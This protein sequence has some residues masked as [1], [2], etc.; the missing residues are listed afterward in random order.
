MST[1]LVGRREERRRAES[2]LDCAPP[3]P[4]VVALIGEAGIGK[5]RLAKWLAAS[6][7]RSGHGVVWGQAAPSDIGLPLGVFQDLLRAEARREGVAPPADPLAA[8]FPQRVLPEL[9]GAPPGQAVGRD[10]V[11]EAAARWFDGRA[12]GGL[13]VVLDDLHWA[14][15][16]SLALAAHLIRVG[17]PARLRFI[18]AFRDERSTALDEFRRT[19][20]RLAPG[21]E[22]VLGPVSSDEI[23]ELVAG[24]TNERLDAQQL[25]QVA[26]LSG[27]NPFVVEELVLSGIATAADAAS[28]RLTW[29]LHDIVDARLARLSATASETVRWAAV[30]GERFDVTLLGHLARIDGS[31]FHAT[32]AELR[33]A[34]VL[35]DHNDLTDRAERM[36]FRHALTQVAI[37]ERMPA[38][39]RHARHRQILAAFDDGVCVP[40]LEEHLAHAQAAADRGRVVRLSVEAAGRA[41]GQGALSDADAHYRTA[42]ELWQTEDGERLR[43]DLAAEW[44]AL[45]GLLQP[46]PE[47]VERLRDAERRYRAL[48]DEIAAINARVQG[49]HVRWKAGDPS[50][51]S[52][53][54]ALGDELRDAPV[55]ARVRALSGAANTMLLIGGD[56]CEAVRLADQ[57]LALVDQMEGTTATLE[58]LRC[59]NAVGMGVL[60]LG[61]WARARDTLHE[62]GRLAVEIGHPAGPVIALGN[63]VVIGQWD[64]A[65]TLDD[66][67]VVAE[68]ALAEA[69]VR[70]M[71]GYQAWMALSAASLSLRMGRVADTR[72]FREQGAAALADAPDPAYE[73]QLVVVD[74]QM[75]LVAGKLESARRRFAEVLPQMQAAL[76]EAER[77]ARLGLAQ[78]H[79]ALDAPGEALATIA[80]WA[81]LLT[82]RP[83]QLNAYG[84]LLVAGVEAATRDGD[85]RGQRWARLIA[86]IAP[87]PRAEL[88]GALVAIASGDAPPGR[89]LTAALDDLAVSGRVW[90]AARMALVLAGRLPVGSP[91][92]GELAARARTAFLDIHVDGWARRAERLLRTAGSRVASRKTSGG[93]GGLTSREV[94]VLQLVADG[95]SNTD[96]A[97][98]LHLSVA[99]VETHLRNVFR[100]LGVRRRTQAVRVAG[101]Q[102]LLDPV[103][104]DTRRA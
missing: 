63:L 12:R 73:R 94:E 84:S 102:G 93:A 21:S 77:D 25:A 8:G 13:T 90:E 69:T 53:L 51:A 88:A 97:A 9:G 23:A 35:A 48:G 47:A 32:L 76:D 66:V 62:C 34:G 82:D 2:L 43:A 19:L 80:Q 72:R 54:V 55:P 41:A 30:L 71:R 56:P 61:D 15:S 6:V 89:R 101:E 20:A 14:D 74:A 83:E 29:P 39:E 24:L 96:L 98:R 78:A 46:G 52:D 10:V 17:D 1:D 86:Q 42:W 31:D 100:K 26:R 59:L 3:R 11:F 36:A 104:G 103:S 85:E 58:R 28:E 67:A 87:G 37:A 60:Q 79:L 45:G 81:D 44:G 22:I 49:C 91:L 4:A 65:P 57:G 40:Q 92:G 16:S 68:R 50:G 33:D 18:V 27:G 99:T 95:L 38:A 75:D 70:G 7:G 64:V 5:T